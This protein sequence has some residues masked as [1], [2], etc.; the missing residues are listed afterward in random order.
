MKGAFLPSLGTEDNEKF[1]ISSVL[2]IQCVPR[3]ASHFQIGIT[4]DIFN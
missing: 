2:K 3:K 1:S 4:Q